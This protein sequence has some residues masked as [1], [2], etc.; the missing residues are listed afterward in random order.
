MTRIY[1]DTTI[2]LHAKPLGDITWETYETPPVT[3]IITKT[4]IRELDRQKD[5]H[6][7]K[8]SASAPDE[9]FSA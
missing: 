4:N 7:R 8:P 6:P 5:Q 9:H 1:I 2:L 3:I